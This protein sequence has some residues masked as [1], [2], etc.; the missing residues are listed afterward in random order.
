MRLR[1]ALAVLCA[2]AAVVSCARGDDAL[3]GGARRLLNIVKDE[4]TLRTSRL[5]CAHV[6]AC[7][8]SARPFPEV[9][10]MAGNPRLSDG[11]CFC[12]GARK[13]ASCAGLRGGAKVA[14]HDH[15]ALAQG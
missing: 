15:D 5:V 8:T 1:G 14:P 10:R 13:R 9:A 6:A 3:R 12:R 7:G 11:T 4:Q 2:A